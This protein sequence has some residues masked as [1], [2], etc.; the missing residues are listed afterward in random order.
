[1]RLIIGGSSRVAERFVAANPD[2]KF[3]FANRSDI[4]SWLKRT[5]FV[6]FDN[7]VSALPA[8]L[9]AVYV[10]AGVTDP[11]SDPDELHAVNVRL[12]RMVLGRA[13]R[14]GFAV[15]TYG[16]ALEALGQT[17]NVYLESKR[18]LA[19]IVADYA[20][21]GVDA[22]HV[23]FHTVYGAGVPQ[24]HMFLGQMLEALVADAPFKMS[25]GT[26]L[27]EYHHVDDL[28][29]ALAVLDETRPI[30][31]IT[32]THGMPVALRALAEAVFASFDRTDLLHVGAIAAPTTEVHE[33][34]EGRTV[35]LDSVQFREPIAGVVDYMHAAYDQVLAERKGNGHE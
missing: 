8:P 32:I 35:G 13:A 34:S 21:S 4:E 19:A 29:A 23:R 24:R 30:P 14:D 6:G 7:F 15:T 17:P 1:M 31:A 26:Q 11:T 10:F 16:T 33:Q 18:E 5:D 27:R 25:S 22:L 28:V 20:K 12:P 9:R 3:L 2:E